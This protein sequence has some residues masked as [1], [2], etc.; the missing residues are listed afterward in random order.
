MRRGPPRRPSLSTVPP[1][2][3][4]LRCVTPFGEL[5]TDGERLAGPP[6]RAGPP[7]AAQPLGCQPGRPSPLFALLLLLRSRKGRP[8][9]GATVEAVSECP[10]QS[11]S[12]SGWPSEHK[13]SASPPLAYQ[14]SA[15]MRCSATC[16]CGTH[17]AG[18]YL[19]RRGDALVELAK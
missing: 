6:P 9:K 7:L 4:P 16:A 14:K 10:A 8:L 18:G 19:K 5:A 1:G 11:R 2:G 15:F 12:A 13:Q 17:C 3:A